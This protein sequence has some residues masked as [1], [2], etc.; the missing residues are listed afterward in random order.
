M[1][2]TTHDAAD[3]R[4]A[5]QSAET[6]DRATYDVVI[7]GSGVSALFAA[8]ELLR[9]RP[10]TR[11]LLTDAGLPL[12]DRQR[13]GTGDW[14]G[15]GGAGLYLGGRVYLGPASIPVLPP[16]STSPELRPILSGAAYEERAREVNAL[17]DTLG[18]T[19]PLREAPHAGIVAAI[20]QA[21]AVGLEYV[22]SYPARFLSVGERAAV[23]GAF[24]QALQR[25]GAQFSFGT[26]VHAIE[27]RAHGF[28]VELD[29]SAR[30]DIA[31]QQI[32]TPR[33]QTRTLLL[34]PGRYGAEWL[35]QVAGALGV[36]AVALPVAFGV[37]LELAA[38][39]YAP[40][41]EINP[42]PR[43]QLPLPDDA[44][45][46]TYATCP[47]GVVTA[48][49]RYGRFVASGVPLMGDAKRP[50]TTFAVLAQAGVRGA[51]GAWQSGELPAQRLNAQH[52]GALVV[53]RLDD[54]RQQ[55]PTSAAAL[56]ANSVAPTYVTAVPGALHDVYPAIYWHAFEEFLQRISRL[57]PAVQ[58]GDALLYGP[59]EEQFWHFPTDD[60]L[61][62]DVPGIFVAGD[63]AG[64]SQG[65]TQAA[66]AG[67]LAGGG[68]AGAL[69]GPR[70]A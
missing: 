12:D 39:A 45:I 60:T 6:S 55:R 59:A 51:A 7:A 52:S 40:L 64:Q 35:V 8:Y 67:L 41:T 44:V 62:T 21:A 16:T 50:S 29:F 36:R 65:I 31:L 10:G 32:D 66:V 15:Y 34:A 19:A 56:A 46:R 69:A 38:T 70:D 47:G 5:T 25:L 23:L 33:V 58:H 17:L 3:T 20:E 27:R 28:A 22:T 14:G 13:Y 2:R 49:T 26:S 57:A 68:L 1:T 42:D 24:A 53:Q 4:Q 54:L 37:R 18:A 43:L 9:R 61:E 11:V 48:L 30:R 63:G